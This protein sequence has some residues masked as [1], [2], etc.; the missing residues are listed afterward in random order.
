M[1]VGAFPVPSETFIARQ[2][3]GLLDLGHEVDIY[4][5]TRGDLTAPRPAEVDRYHLLERTTFMDLPPECAP[6]ELPAWPADGE[7]WIPGAP[8]PL[9]NQDRLA[10]AAIVRERCRAQNARLTDQVL[11]EAEY[12]YRALSL[13]ALHRLDR[14]SGIPRQYDAVHA[15][16]GPMGESFRF[17]RDLWQAPYI[18]SFHGYDFCTVPRREGRDCYARLFQTAD[19]VTVNSN[20]T[21]NQVRSLGCVEARLRKLPMGFDPSA[22]SFAERRPAP[23]IRL[24]SVARLVA[25]KG[26]EY[27][28]RA[29]AEARSRVP[30][31]YD[32]VGEGEERG[33]LETLAQELGLQDVVTFHGAMTGPALNSLLNAAH[34]F[35]LCSVDVHGDQEGQGLALV[36]AQACGLPVIAT[37]HGGLPESM[38]EGGSGWL[39]PERDVAA[40]AGRIAEAVDCSNEWPA[41]GRRGRAWVE[42]HFDVRTLNK[43]LADFYR[44]SIMERQHSRALNA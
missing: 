19:L 28:L 5:D 32:V 37:R 14:L 6:W 16:F 18:V 11:D 26:H 39:V 40:L 25:I 33:K 21:W 20:Y 4:A 31:H 8:A 30:L 43:R 38:I 1:F 12:G 9:R 15:H 13:S 29:V 35:L 10:R 7:T 3:A 24:I 42:E 22:C 2:I 23:V 44:E 36:E 27:C 34:L 41:M 17:T